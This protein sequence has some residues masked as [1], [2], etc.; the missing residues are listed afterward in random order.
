MV[1][2]LLEWDTY[3]DVGNGPS[4]TF[5]RKVYSSEANAVAARDARVTAAALV[6]STIISAAINSVTVDG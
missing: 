3:V 4:R 6:G 1:V 2:W 5:L